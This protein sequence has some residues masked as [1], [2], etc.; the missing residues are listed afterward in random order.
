MLARAQELGRRAVQE[1]QDSLR[2]EEANEFI[3][4]QKEELQ[5]KKEARR[6]KKLEQERATIEEEPKQTESQE[7]VAEFAPKVSKDSS[8]GRAPKVS[9]EG[10]EDISFSSLE[11]VVAPEPEQQQPSTPKPR[12][13]HFET[14][15]GGRDSESDICSTYSSFF[16]RLIQSFR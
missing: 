13:P 2:A 9:K 11:D 4:A 16:S 1:A 6:A 15:E 10:K 12:K 5:K 7:E 8:L 3:F 14:I